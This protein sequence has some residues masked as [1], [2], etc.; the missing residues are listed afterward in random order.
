VLPKVPCQIIFTPETAAGAAARGGRVLD[1]VPLRMQVIDG[2]A[3][4]MLTSP[5]AETAVVVREPL[6]VEALA[7]YFDLLWAKAVPVPEVSDVDD[8]PGMSSVQRAIM[9]LLVR[10]MT[11]VAVSKVL[12]ISTR[13]VRR[14]VAALEERAGVASRFALGAAAMRL[15]WLDL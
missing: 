15:G 2:T 11:D 9:K 1:R 5:G 8:E 10:G 7:D 14:H 12:G 4:V 13:S 3:L 6:I